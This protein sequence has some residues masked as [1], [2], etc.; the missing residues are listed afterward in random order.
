MIWKSMA[1]DQVQIQIRNVLK[2]VQFWLFHFTWLA[3]QYFIKLYGLICPR[4]LDS[5]FAFIFSG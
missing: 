1:N 3:P 2:S 5:V 4:S